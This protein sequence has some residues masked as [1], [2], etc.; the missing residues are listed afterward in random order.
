MKKIFAS[1]L[2]SLFFFGVIHA[3]NPALASLDLYQINGQWQLRADFAWSIRNAVVNQ[4][5]FLEERS[6]NHEEYLDC[7]LEYMEQNIQVSL[8]N[9]DLL[10]KSISQLPGDHGHDYI[11]LINLTG[12]QNGKTLRI[13]NKCLFDLYKKSR[14]TIRLAGQECLIQSKQ[15]VCSFSL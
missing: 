2:C 7:I 4:F 11:F 12:P 10:F 6:A 13:Q 9:Q 8:D 3:H 5:P 15:D 1:I 14:H